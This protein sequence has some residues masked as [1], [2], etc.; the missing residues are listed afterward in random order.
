[1]SKVLLVDTNYSSTPIYHSLIQD[2]HDVYVAGNNSTEILAK[3]CKNYIN[4]D[5]SDSEELAKIIKSKNIEKIIPG[6]T[7]VSYA[8]CAKIGEKNPTLWMG[9]SYKNFLIINNKRQ[10][11]ETASNLNIPIPKS[12]EDINS[13]KKAAKKL[14]IKPADSF[15]GKGISTVH[16]DDRNAL[17]KAISY[18][19]NISPS[20]KIIIEDFV[21]GQLYSY[22]AFLSNHQVQSAFLVQ[23]D[24]TLNPYSV[25]SSFVIHDKKSEIRKKLSIYIERLSKHLNLTDGL[26]HTQFICNKN[27]FWLI[28]ITRRCPG[29][30]YSNLIEY[31]TGFP[32]A[33]QYKNY[34]L[35]EVNNIETASPI[36]KNKIIR[37]TVSTNTNGILKSIEF[38]KHQKIK[39]YISLKKLG[40][41]ISNPNGERI[42]LLF[43]D[44]KKHKKKIYQNF[45]ERNFYQISIENSAK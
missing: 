11:K 44:A 9:D 14:I 13:A 26:I 12:Y 18:A 8:S 35:R 25:D 43:I 15:S 27:E 36:K 29:D 45:L 40:D 30:Q 22:S 32:Y 5:Y 19:K 17:L 39:K 38:K 20:K 2:G 31:S 33:K 16:S 7:D 34:F 1:M 10:F 3:I 24:C 41:S 23:E 21:N 37:H 42:G 4:I 28:E 6:C